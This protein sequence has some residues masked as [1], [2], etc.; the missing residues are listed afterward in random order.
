MIL[1]QVSTRRQVSWNCFYEKILFS[2]LL[3]AFLVLRNPGEKTVSTRHD[4]FKGDIKV[5]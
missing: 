1:Q 3:K 2:S 4:I 5:R